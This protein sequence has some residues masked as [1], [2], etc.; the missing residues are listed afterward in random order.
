MTA[1][2]N[3]PAARPPALS[4]WTLYPPIFLFVY[5]THITLLRLPYFWDETGY[6]IPA[7][8][9]C[10]RTGTLIPFSTAANSH[11]PLPSILLALWWHVAGFSPIATRT[12]LCLVTA[13]S[14]LAV[15]RLA[16]TL[17]SASASL[18]VTLLTALYPIWFAQST[19]AHADTFAA[20]F[21]LFALALYAEHIHE[22]RP[23]AS[24]LLFLALNLSLSVVAKESA[25]L[26]PLVLGLFE[27]ARSLRHRLRIATLAAICAPLLPLIAW[28]A[29][30]RHR[31]GYI[32]GNPGYLSYNATAN[33]TPARVGF[34]IIHRF[35][36]LSAHMNLCVPVLCAL[37]CLLLRPRAGSS[38]IPRSLLAL[39]ALL[40]A[41]NWLFYSFMGGALLTRY[42]LPA[43][44]L[45]LILCTAVWVR[46]T[47]RWWIPALLT[48]AAFI[49]AIHVN[50]PYRFAPE[51][52]LAYRDMIVLQQQAVHILTTQ[53]PDSTVLTSWPLTDEL[54][55]PELGYV[56]TPIPFVSIE[57]FTAPQLTQA[58]A[59]TPRP[60]TTAVVFSTKLEP[61]GSRRRGPLLGSQYFDY[62]ADLAPTEAAVVLGGQIVWQ[63]QRK[64]QWAAVVRF[65]Q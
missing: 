39:F 11:P 49:F 7:A 14:L 36:H 40:L 6:Y 38:R 55:R 12:L 42:L 60:Y 9:D 37:A 26:V 62:H 28:Y 4:S 32:F 43:Y 3:P 13:L 33:L 57:N 58:A 50:P 23:P 2:A 44:P 31:T 1:H 52:N 61:S 54:R 35:I 64:G 22:D 65:P 21:T 17:L 25:L 20:A 46:R 27:L 34:A 45:V 30:Y 63:S 48:T 29:F 59:L 15:Y 18:A 56:R 24:S 41:A 10:F 51:D 5:L 16:R 47:A 53:F 19:L 8:F